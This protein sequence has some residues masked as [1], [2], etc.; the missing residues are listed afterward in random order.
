[1]DRKNYPVSVVPYPIDRAL[2][3]KMTSNDDSAESDAKWLRPNVTAMP[4][5]KPLSIVQ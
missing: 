5:E 3:V 2:K 1:M 4:A